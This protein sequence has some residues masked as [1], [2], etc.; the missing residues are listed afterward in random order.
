MPERCEDARIAAR[1]PDVREA[2]PVRS[3][4]PHPG[5]PTRELLR[6]AWPLILSASFVTLQIVL[7]RVL[8]S[9]SSSAA[10]GAGM[11]AALLFWVFLSLLQNTANYATTFVAQYTGAGQPRHTGP[12]VWQSLHFSLV[13]GLAFLGLIPL[14]GVIV[15]VGQH[16]PELQGL[17]V[18]YFRCLCVAALPMLV[19][20]SASSFFAGRGDSRTVLGINAAGLAVN[21]VCAYAW[22]FGHFGFAARGI[23]GAGWATVAGSSTSAALA[24]ALMLRPSYRAEF[25]T[26]SWRPDP[27]LLRRLLR[28]GLPN[29]IFALLDVLGFTAFMQLVGRLGEVELAATSIACTLNLLAFLPMWGLGQ[30]VEVL[31]GQRLG[32]DRPDEAERVTWTGLRYS[33]GF[34][35]VVALLYVVAPQALALPFRSEADAA[36][37]ARV[38]AMVPLLLRFVT[39]YCLFDACNLILS[40]AL[41]GAGDTRFVTWV[42]LALSWPVMVLP[43][44]A[45]WH[46]GW[47][48]YAAWGFASL[49]IILLAVTFFFRFRQ[50]K[51]R[52]MRVIETPRQA[53]APAVG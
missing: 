23:A 20:A 11:S 13:S 39:V 40:F 21:G 18:T 35:A 15:S 16:A 53:D 1:G 24:L 46:Y 37:W 5:S 26:G 48:L 44:W 19:T 30:A 51:W 32:E 33:L 34:T 25:A 9:R 45:A 4:S 3:P 47:G 8:L 6:L 22:I 38:G 10:V 41:R 42:A 52:S 50:G 14:A 28:F 2:L 43:T 49:Y 29:G 27:A 12:V 36:N 7:D 31:V 17:E